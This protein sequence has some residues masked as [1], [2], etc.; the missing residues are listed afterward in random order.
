MWLN[1][2]LWLVHLHGAGRQVARWPYP[3]PFPSVRNRV[4]PCET[5]PNDAPIL[6]PM[7][8]SIG[9]STIYQLSITDTPVYKSIVQMKQIKMQTMHANLLTRIS[10]SMCWKHMCTIQ[11]ILFCYGYINQWSSCNVQRLMYRKYKILVSVPV[12]Q[13][14]ISC[15]HDYCYTC[16]AGVPL[17]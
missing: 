1:T 13:G 2:V 10:T 5:I 6:I 8:V 17:P 15:C 11:S 7:S 4:W 9:I 12:F 16:A 3:R 14:I